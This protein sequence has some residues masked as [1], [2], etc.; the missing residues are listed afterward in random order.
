MGNVFNNLQPMS[1]K[2]PTKKRLEFINYAWVAAIGFVVDL[3]ILIL[4][5]DHLKIPYL[6]SASLGFSIGLLTNFY[7]SEKFV[8]GQSSI[9]SMRVRFF[10][11]GAIGASGL[12]LLE[13]FMWLQVE[14]LAISY[15]H[16][17]IIATVFVYL[18]NYSARSRLYR[19]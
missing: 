10:W 2:F 7:L 16:A 3:G 4:A 12:A 14:C 1:K 9:S 13:L 8:F 15:I 18:W 5:T 6:I 17:K 11:F 19:K